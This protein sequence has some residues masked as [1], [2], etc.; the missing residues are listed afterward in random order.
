[1]LIFCG[2]SLR[3]H[4]KKFQR[5]LK[6]KTVLCTI[7]HIDEKKFIGDEGKDFYKLD[8][9]VDYYHTISKNLLIN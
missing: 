1:M 7:H 6:Q 9:F 8:K 5:F 4:G 3:G 2:S